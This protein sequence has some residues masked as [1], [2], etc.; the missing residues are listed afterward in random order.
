LNA[1]DLVAGV[2]QLASVARIETVSLFGIPSPALTLTHLAQVASLLTSRF[3]EGD[4]DGAVIVQ[5]TD[6]IEDTAF[7]LDRLMAEER[8]IVVTG[9]MRGPEA[10]GADGPAN[11]LAAVTVAGSKRAAASG[12]LV[13]MNDEIHAAQWVQKTHTSLTSA[14]ASPGVGR[15]GLVVEGR[16]E[17]MSPVSRRAGRIVLDNPLDCAVAVVS[18]GMGEDG[19][20]LGAL[21]ALDYQ[22][23]VIEAMGAGHVPPTALG[24]I[25]ALAATMP[26]VLT[27]RV[28][29]GFIFRDTYGFAGS[30]RDLI[31]RGVIP[32]GHLTPSKARLLLSL[33]LSAGSG[34]EEVR[35]AF[36]AS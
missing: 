32:A 11:V 24:A 5:G 28:R 1:D 21:T 18:L 22:G 27:S 7:V 16:V 35:S 13:V 4:L 3:S 33:L 36:E 31:A 2:A 29:A 17:M 23:A 14:F 20:I 30:E 8:P 10:A 26:V 6:T 9:A 12:V 19:R 15:V 34:V 25:T